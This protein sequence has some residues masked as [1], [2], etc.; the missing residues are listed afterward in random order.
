MGRGVYRIKFRS[1]EAAK[2]LLAL[3]MRELRES[4]QPL[5]VQSVEQL[6]T[7]LEI[8]EVITEKLTGRERVDMHNYAGEKPINAVQEKKTPQAKPEPKPPRFSQPARE[9]AGGRGGHVS[10]HIPVNPPYSAGF[11]VISPSHTSQPPHY[12]FKSWRDRVS[13]GKGG[14]QSSA[15]A[16]A[17][18]GAGTWW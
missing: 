11:E 1:K 14:V 8:F 12:P 15:T 5:K 6:L 16:P 13:T 17:P 2:K 9:P 7:T 18:S 3:H 4:P 10:S